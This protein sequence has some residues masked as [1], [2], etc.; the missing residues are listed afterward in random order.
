MRILIAGGGEVAL[1]IARRLIREGN[2]IA[3]VEQDAD[4]CSV[5]EQNLDAHVVCGSAASIRI[6]DQAGLKKAEMLIAITH[7]DAINVL[8]CMAAQAEANVKIKVARLRTPEVEQWSSILRKLDVRLDLII[9]P[10]LEATTR[11]LKVLRVPGVSDIMDFA[12]GKIK[13]FGMNIE[14]DSWACGKTLEE[15]DRAGPPRNSLIAMIF[16]G[17]EVIIPH[18]DERLEAGDHAYII[19]AEPDLPAV[20]RF[21][22]I[23]TH[24]LDRV[25]IFG[26]R[27]AGI[28]MA[29]QLER[30]G[31]AVKLFDT[32]PRRCEKIAALVKDTIVINADATDESVLKEHNIQDADA[33]LALTADDEDNIIA[34]L[35][36]RRLGANKVVAMTDHL[37]YF[38]MAQ[39][40]GINTLVSPRLA[41]VDRILQFVRK[42]RVQSV[43]TFREEEAEAIELIAAPQSRFVGKRLS[44]LRLPRE[45]IVGAIARP[46]GEV[47]VPRGNASI[48][49]GDRVIFFALSKIVP[50][51]ESAFLSDAYKGS[52]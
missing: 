5:L 34:C 49:S 11:I 15:L 30:Q 9:Q 26:G 23:K 48:E 14:P 8:A 18:G 37:N 3:I 2:E 39:R 33:Y 13:L 41:A 25:F 10:D 7:E 17:P 22:G 43:T 4:R 1:L 31:I 27:Q 50:K 40:L 45:A 36:A 12:G 44:E 46:N 52:K 21:M 20:M 19:T 42:G 6:L 29:Q 28:W 47:M 16:R 32:D 38:T 24:R 51:L 35:L